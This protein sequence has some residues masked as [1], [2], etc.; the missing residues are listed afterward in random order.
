LVNINSVGGCQA[1]SQWSDYGASKFALKGFTQSLR[2]GNK[3]YSI[4]I[5]LEFEEEIPYLA[6]TNVYPYYI[7]TGMFEG[8]KPMAEK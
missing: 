6:M 1:L 2:F 8:Y 7:N 4:D 5:F 3:I